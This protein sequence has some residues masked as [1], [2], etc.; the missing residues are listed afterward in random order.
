MFKSN[1]DFKLYIQDI[2][3]EC[4]ILELLQKMYPM[5]ISQKI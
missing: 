3:N 5:K 2:H 4:K 1:R